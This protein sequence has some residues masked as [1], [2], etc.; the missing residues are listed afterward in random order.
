MF[1]RDDLDGGARRPL[2]WVFGPLVA[3]ALLVTALGIVVR[4]T[5]GFPDIE[6]AERLEHAA[7]EGDPLLADVTDYAWDRV[8]VFPKDLP[9]ED[10][11]ATLGIA[12]G[13]VG[14]DTISNR[15]LLVF[16]RAGNVVRHFYLAHGLVD[17][18]APEG[19]CRL[20]DDESTRL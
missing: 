19:D 16:V 12:W 15:D 10:V 4:G 1:S 8:C 11:D 13:V 7:G 14:G 6:L 2:L 18:P 3:G 5:Q 20:P 9:K 17:D